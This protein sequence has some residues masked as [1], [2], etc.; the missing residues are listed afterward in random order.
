MNGTAQAYYSGMFQ[1]K[2][3]EVF[4]CVLHGEFEADSVI[5]LNS[6][7]SKVRCPICGRLCRKIN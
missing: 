1:K 2:E 7:Q 5:F 6:F 4:Y 3:R